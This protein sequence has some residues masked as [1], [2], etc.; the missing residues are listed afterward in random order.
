MGPA[1]VMVDL[2]ERLLEDPS[3]NH[4]ALE[5]SGTWQVGLVMGLM[6]LLVV[7]YAGLMGG[8]DRTY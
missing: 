6:G 7:S 2:R 1:Q 3:R 4:Q 5:H 8:T